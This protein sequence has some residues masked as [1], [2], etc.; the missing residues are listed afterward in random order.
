MKE[1]A[2][3]IADEIEQRKKERLVGVA[4]AS[5]IT[6]LSA[7]SLYNRKNEIGYTKRGRSLM[8]SVKSLD[9]YNKI[10]E[11]QNRGVEW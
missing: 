8:F 9:L 6:G 7:Q 1:L 2:V 3:M 10:R 11:N 4:E 5:E